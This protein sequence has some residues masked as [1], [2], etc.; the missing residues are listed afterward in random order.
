MLKSLSASALL[1]MISFLVHIKHLPR[2]KT[3]CNMHR[4][5]CERNVCNLVNEVHRKTTLW[6]VKTFD[7]IIIPPFNS[8]EMVKKTRHRKI[9]SRTVHRMMTWVHARFQE[10]LLSKV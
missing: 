6:L 1:L 8:S 3:Q 10:R 7:A 9:S 2:S 5:R 4:H